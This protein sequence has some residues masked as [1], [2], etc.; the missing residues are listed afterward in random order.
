MKLVCP[1]CGLKGRAEESLFEQDV[2]CPE[3]KT[4][5]R[6]AVGVLVGGAHE[7]EAVTSAYQSLETK[8]CDI[9]GFVLSTKYLTEIGD[10]LYCQVCTLS[11]GRREAA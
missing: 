3:C 6:L 9:C 8:T 7:Q 5:F 4:V 11:E 1:Q 2:K 10:K